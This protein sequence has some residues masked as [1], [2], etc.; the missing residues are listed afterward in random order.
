MLEIAGFLG[1]EA[2]AELEAAT[3]SVSNTTTACRRTDRVRAATLCGPAHRYCTASCD[4]RSRKGTSDATKSRPVKVPVVSKPWRKQGSAISDL[5][6]G[7]LPPTRERGADKKTLPFSSATK[8][9]T[10]RTR[11]SADIKLCARCSIICLA[12]PSADSNVYRCVQP[13]TSSLSCFS[14][15]S[16]ASDIAPKAM[17]EVFAAA[18][19]PAFAAPS[20]RCVLHGLVAFISCIGRVRRSN[21]M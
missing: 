8:A 5:S 6:R 9:R 2:S 11:L 15:C 20:D 19:F 7:H 21:S 17:S 14:E 13:D 3:C 1:L 4:V 16:R 12:S 10:R 18:F